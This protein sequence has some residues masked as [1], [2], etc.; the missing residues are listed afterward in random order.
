MRN[1]SS[2]GLFR[3][4][5]VNAS[6]RSRSLWWIDLI[7]RQKLSFLSSS[8]PSRS[9]WWLLKTRTLSSQSKEYNHSHRRDKTSWDKYS[10]WSSL[11]RI[12]SRAGR[13]NKS[14]SRLRLNIVTKKQMNWCVC[15]LT[16][17]A[18]LESHR[19]KKPFYRNDREC[20]LNDRI[21]RMKSVCSSRQSIK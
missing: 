10:Q 18:R 5:S 2:G 8:K 3:A 19:W 7:L 11:K 6:P 20:S 12:S 17:P 9:V 15:S 21:E 16:K 13:R 1:S 4:L 14:Q